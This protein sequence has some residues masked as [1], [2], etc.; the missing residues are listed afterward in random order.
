MN[1]NLLCFCLLGIMIATARGQLGESPDQCDQRYGS[2]AVDKGAQGCWMAAR[3]Y[4]QGDF[5]INVRFL[6]NSMGTKVAGWISYAPAAG[7]KPNAGER[8]KI[9]E[10]ASTAWTPVE[11]T[12]ITDEMDPQLH[13]M[14]KIHNEFVA[15]TKAT[16]AQVTGWNTMR[17][18]ISPTIYAADNGVSLILFTEAYLAQHKLQQGQ[19][20]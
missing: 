16:F 18:W 4:T 2:N 3:E 19:K 13:E 6:T 7:I 1:L 17:C 10:A 9:R 5:L 12:V 15:V 20:H 8:Q 14:A 11:E